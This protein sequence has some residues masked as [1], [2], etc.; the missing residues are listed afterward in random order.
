M[1]KFHV[2]WKQNL[3]VMPDDPAK[4]GKINI[5]LLEMVKADV[6]SNKITDW[7]VYCNGFSGYTI[8]EGTHDEIMTE[9]LK[10][11][12]YILF[13]VKPVINEDQAIEAVKVVS[14]MMKK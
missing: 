11:M 4:L 9:L 5:S 3:S 12:P 6:K 1:P 8:I 2:E 13:E 10:Y 14:Q 7:G